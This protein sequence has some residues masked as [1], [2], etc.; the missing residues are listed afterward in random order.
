MKIKGKIEQRRPE[1]RRPRT[2]I[3]PPLSPAIFLTIY[4]RA[5]TVMYARPLPHT[6][7]TNTAPV[8]KALPPK[9][10]TTNRFR[11]RFLDRDKGKV[12]DPWLIIF[13]SISNRSK[14]IIVF[15][16]NKG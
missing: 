2:S 13:D 6:A 11:A 15:K 1:E 4:P 8:F 10:S 5:E 3:G 14:L 12:G 9:L 16:E 7:N